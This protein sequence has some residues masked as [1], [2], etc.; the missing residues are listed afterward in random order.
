MSVSL[1]V[2]CK[3]VTCCVFEFYGIPPVEC[4]DYFYG[5]SV[6]ESADNGGGH[7]RR[8]SDIEHSA[9][10]ADGALGGEYQR[11]KRHA[12][13]IRNAYDKI[14]G[15]RGDVVVYPPRVLL[16]VVLGELEISRRGFRPP[17]FKQLR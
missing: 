12:E 7:I 5:A 17:E 10:R 11:M 13:K 8:A 16:V 2:S 6:G 14:F 15:Y 3:N 1:D 4:A 9:L